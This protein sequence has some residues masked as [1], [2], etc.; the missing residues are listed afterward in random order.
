M[1]SSLLLQTLNIQDAAEITQVVYRDTSP[2]LRI[3]TVCPTVATAAASG[4]LV[5]LSIFGEA[6]CG[7]GRMACAAAR[8][9]KPPAAFTFSGV[10]GVFESGELLWRPYREFVLS[11]YPQGQ[12]VRPAFPPLVG[13]LILALR[14]EGLDIEQERI[15]RSYDSL[16]L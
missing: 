14:K 16:V 3:A 1:L 4:D 8:K 2:K 7:L 5:A 9:L 13:A 15:R 6:G 10:G 11:E 12:V